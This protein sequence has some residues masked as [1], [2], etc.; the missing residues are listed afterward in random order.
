M[1]IKIQGYIE[2]FIIWS[3]VGG[4]VFSL[5]GALAASQ[6]NSLPDDYFESEGALALV[7]GNS[8]IS[9]T[10]HYLTEPRAVDSKIIKVVVTA[11]S[12]CPTETDDDPYITASGAWVHDGVAAANF[13][14]FGTEIRIPEI[15]GDKIFVIE[16]RM[17]PRKTRQVDIWFS[18]KQ[19]ALDFGA[20]Y[21][22]IEVLEI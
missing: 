7:Q 6:D 17:H 1:R 16:D 9:N 19:G 21:S 13:L 4:V 11:Y 5:S 12:S 10:E 18:S 14:P 3:V 22:Y 20:R 2:F 8:V 15:Y